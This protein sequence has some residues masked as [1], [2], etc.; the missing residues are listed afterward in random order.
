MLFRAFPKADEGE[1]S[2][3]LADLVRK[4]T[5]AEV[6]LAIDLGAAI[7]LG[8]SEANAGGRRRLAILAD[9]CEALVGAVFT[10]GGYPAAAA[11]VERL[12][13]ERMRTRRPGRC[14]IPRRCCR[15]GRRRAA[16]RPRPIARSS[17]PGRITTRNSASRSRCRRSSRPR[18][19]AAPNARP[20]RL[21]PPMLMAEGVEVTLEV[22]NGEVASSEAANSE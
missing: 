17:A 14:V 21:R 7:K 10:D 6:A 2:R 3:R 18:A 16:C 9:V 22:P 13:G 20:S 19:S 12:W 1:L 8:T 15:N 11:M 4:E 5:C